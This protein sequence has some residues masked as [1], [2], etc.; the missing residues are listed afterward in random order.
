MA[1]PYLNRMDLAYAAADLAIS[2]LGGG[3]GGRVVRRPA[4][5]AVYVPLPIEQW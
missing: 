2:P 5:P 3:D 4:C 1:V